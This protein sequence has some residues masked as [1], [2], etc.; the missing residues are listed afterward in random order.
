MP[1]EDEVRKKIFILE[2]FMKTLKRKRLSGSEKERMVTVS[3]YCRTK[4]ASLFLL[5]NDEVQVF[6]NDKVEFLLTKSEVYV[7][8]KNSEKFERY[9]Y[10][11]FD[12][13]MQLRR[14]YCVAVAHKVFSWDAQPEPN[15]LDTDGLDID[16]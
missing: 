16:V 12:N 5:T 6:F 9:D 7:K 4:Y 1:E 14:D 11:K 3:Q 13:D 15:I 10:A 8:C 2:A